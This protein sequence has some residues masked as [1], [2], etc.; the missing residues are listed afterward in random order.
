MVPVKIR[1]S[2]YQMEFIQRRRQITEARIGR[3]WVRIDP[4]VLMN[5]CSTYGRKQRKKIRGSADSPVII[6]G[7]YLKVL[8]KELVAVMRTYDIII[9]VGYFKVLISAKEIILLSFFSK[10]SA[11]KKVK[12]P[13][14]MRISTYAIIK[15]IFSDKNMVLT[16]F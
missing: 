5:L 3:H 1:R 15:L 10:S 16:F 11:I 13:I 14:M 2:I 4:K 6:N 12:L 7:E 8:I 9:K